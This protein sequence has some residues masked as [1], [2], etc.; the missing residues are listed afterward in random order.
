MTLNCS[1]TEW[2]RL[3]TKSKQAI[4]IKGMDCYKLPLFSSVKISS[5]LFISIPERKV[6]E[7]WNMRIKADC[8]VLRHYNQTNSYQDD[9][10]A[11]D[12]F[13]ITMGCLCWNEFLYKLYKGVWPRELTIDGTY[14]VLQ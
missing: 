5:G 7:M 1:G 4:F 12:R 10:P 14:L 9:S 13:A 3:T 6:F 8:T 11:K 2:E